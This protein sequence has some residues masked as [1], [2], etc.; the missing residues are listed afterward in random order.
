L[1]KNEVF[2]ISMTGYAYR[3]KTRQDL[4]VILEIK[5]CN[6]RYLEIAVNLPPWLSPYEA[7]IREQLSSFCNRGKIDVFIKIR[8]HNVPVNISINVNAA[9]SY[10]DAIKN[11]T[12]ELKISEKPNL[13]AILNMES[14]H[15]NSI[16]EIEKKRDVE[17]YWIDIEPLLNEA[18]KLFCAEREREGKYTEEDILGNLEKIRNSLKIITSFVP[19]IEKTLKDNVK[20]RFE[21]LLGSKIDENRILTETA[22]LLI[23][24]T[25]SEEISRLNSHL[26]EFKKETANNSRPGKKLD[27]L[28]QEI[29][30]EINTIGSKSS[31]IE[32]TS[33]VVIMK[34]ALENI[35]EQ[36]RNIE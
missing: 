33:E 28:C 15:T 30:R 29:N 14:I 8:E 3:E 7:K 22:S 35:R 23:K 9:K 16:F 13:N 32:V 11:L 31:I 34:E 36:L 10:Y 21:E 18:V 25:I 20:T 4:S 27:F 5:G 6:N 17:H 26:N 24:Y 12:K 19:V 2:M 1:N